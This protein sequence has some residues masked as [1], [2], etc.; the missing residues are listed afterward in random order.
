M[1]GSVINKALPQAN[2]EVTAH[3]SDV[4]KKDDVPLAAVMLSRDVKRY[5]EDLQE[6]G[7]VNKTGEH[8][9]QTT[10]AFGLTPE[11]ILT[12]TANGQDIHQTKSVL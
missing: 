4:T 9:Y 7:A 5:V 10:L 2:F 6:E 11:G 3:L 8:D 1:K 12:M